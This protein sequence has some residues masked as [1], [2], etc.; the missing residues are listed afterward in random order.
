MVWIEGFELACFGFEELKRAGRFDLG[1][2]MV[3]ALWCLMLKPPWRFGAEAPQRIVAL[4][5]KWPG[6]FGAEGLG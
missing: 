3:W 1:V 2:E 6:C 4:V 5:L